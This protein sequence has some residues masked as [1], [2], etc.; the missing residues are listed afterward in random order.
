MKALLVGAGAVG[1]VYGRH[2]QL[3]GADV[4]FFVKEKHR[5]AAERGYTLYPLNKGRAPVR[6]EGFG[7]Y[8][9]P[10]EVRLKAWD[11]VWLCVSATQLLDPWLKPFLDVLPPEATLVSLQPGLGSLEHIEAQGFPRERVVQ[12]LIALISYQA[13][14]PDEQLPEPGVAYWFPPFTP[15]PFSS[16]A[17]E[18]AKVDP[19]VN[20]L[21]A[22][23]CPAKRVAD[24]AIQGAF[25]SALLMPH[26]CAL[27][28]EDWSFARL[29]KS[30]ALRLAGAASREAQQVV[31]KRRGATPDLAL[32][33][34]TQSW[35]MR[36][37]LC[38]APMF[39]PLPLEPYLRYHFT[40]VGDQTRY[41]MQTYIDEGRALKLPTG[42]LEELLA[43][44]PP[45]AAKG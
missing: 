43:A 41:M 40:K 13:P 26:L 12:G 20:G 31:A 22:G 39:V 16:P 36:P 23:G 29:R 1:L 6:F 14:L 27:E 34:A 7:V 28:M 37:L 17:G 33:A 9:S 21:K 44:T 19:V 30:P 32:R 15:S 2:L 8:S 25:G 35:V 4:S 5:P 42:H 45:L 38:A 3:G 11:Q 18:R 24:A 10:D